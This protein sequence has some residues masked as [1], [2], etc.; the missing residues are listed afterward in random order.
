MGS[1]W[2]EISPLSDRAG[3]SHS[4]LRVSVTDR[5]NQRCFYCMP[6]Q[7]V[8]DKPHDSILRYEEI[9]DLV[10][11]LVDLGVRRVRITG[12]EPLVRRGVTSFIRTLSLIEGLQ[13]ISLTTNGTLL[14]ERAQDLADAGLHRVNVSLDS[15][16]PERYQ[17]ITRGGDL[18]TAIAGVQAARAA[19]LT[20]V[21]LNT[22]VL[23]DL[24][25][26][27]AREILLW[28]NAAPRDFIPRF[29]ECMPF[30]DLAAAGTALTDLKKALQRQFAMEPDGQVEGDGPAKYW[31]V[32]ST[33]LRVGFIAPLTQHF[34]SCCNRLRL[35]ADGRL[36]T[37]LG[38][39]HG[40]SLR[41]LLRGGASRDELVEAIAATIRAKPRGHACA[42]G[43]D[44][45]FPNTM[46]EMGG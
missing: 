28:C 31:R 34:C 10:S 45:V 17:R 11:L 32:A 26:D 12:G 3:R 7:G 6:E 14:A 4:Y 22:V 21:K 40:T 13:E 44:G 8:P 18:A 25:P 9:F 36:V 37:C 42:M 16:R 23:P 33:G 29:I 41:D 43:N 19:G 39:R 20:P 24:G 5:C 35:T 1:R 38:H 46:P 15:M 2:D 27:E 30:Q